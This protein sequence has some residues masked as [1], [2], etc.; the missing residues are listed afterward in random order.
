M[1]DL[2]DLDGRFFF[3]HKVLLFGSLIG[4]QNRQLIMP[5]QTA[6][7]LSRKRDQGKTWKI[8]DIVTLRQHLLFIL[9][10]LS[11]SAGRTEAN[12]LLKVTIVPLST[13]RGR[14][15][16][17]LVQPLLSAKETHLPKN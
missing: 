6:G 10:E 5:A 12:D 4:S 3:S 8:P 14:A 1:P 11:K 9:L 17:R 15:A 7:C 13:V 2:L 16:Y